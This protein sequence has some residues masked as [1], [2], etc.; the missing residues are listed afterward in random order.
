MS[1]ADLDAVTAIEAVTFPDPWPRRSLAYEAL[2]NPCGFAFV[3]EWEGIV[4]GYAITHVLYEQAHLINIAVAAA[5][6]GLGLGEAL[7][8]HLMRHA[9]LQGAEEMHLEVRETNMAA[10]SLYVRHGFKILGR[11]DKYYGDGTPALLMR[12]PLAVEK[13]TV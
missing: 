5:R 2:E 8:V 9:A 13:R 6:R 3:I 7:L 11:K 1:E 4:A 12:A 10:V